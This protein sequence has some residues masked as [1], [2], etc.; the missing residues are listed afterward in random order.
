MQDKHHINC[1]V[2]DDE[3]PARDGLVDYVSKL[4]FLKLVGVA[5]NAKDASE[6]LA[7]EQVNLIFID[8]QMP[9]VTGVDFIKK[10]SNRPLIIFT[11]A[12]REFAVEGFELDAVDYLVK[13]IS[14]ER[15]K[16]ACE[17]A[18]SLTTKHNAF[19]EEYLFLKDGT[20]YVKI[21]IN[22]ITHLQAADD[23]VFVYLSNSNRHMVLMPMKKLLKKLPGERFIQT[24]R[25]HAVNKNFVT[26][27]E[28]NRL[29]LGDKQVPVSRL[30]VQEVRDKLTGDNILSKD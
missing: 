26:A 1:I 24:H 3:K 13:P 16:K 28:K 29:M 18:R 5:K 30:K 20:D 8:I 27:V 23:Y 17:K 9:Q 6:L 15:F 12:F 14:F 10:L 7:N 11:T 25:S 4:D 19:E 2:V 21:S 22:E